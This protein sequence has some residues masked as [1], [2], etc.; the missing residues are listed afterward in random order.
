MIKLYHN[1]RCSKSREALSVSEEF[2]KNKNIELQIIEYLKN[3]PG[4][5]ELQQ[6][7]AK[8]GLNQQEGDVRPL[9][10]DN[11]DEFKSL[12][13]QQANNSTLLQA[14]AQHIYAADACSSSHAA[15]PST[16]R[17]MIARLPVSSM[18]LCSRRGCWYVI[19]PQ[20]SINLYNLWK[21]IE[22]AVPV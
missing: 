5:N 17:A 9:V 22:S 7:A 13:L 10:R 18:G 11:E 15:K 21:S 1:P 19:F 4:L 3:P 20:R 12:S 6:L 2:C 14:L 8:L 16:G